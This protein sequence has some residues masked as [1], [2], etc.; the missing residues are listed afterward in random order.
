VPD[1]DGQKWTLANGAVIWL[2][3]T[4]NRQD[5]ITMT[6]FSRG[7]MSIIPAADLPSAAFVSSAK[8]SCGTG[9]M[10]APDLRKFL[11]GKS[12]GVSSSLNELDEIVS[13]TSTNKDFE[14]MLQLAYLSIAPPR[15]DDAVLKSIQQRSIAQLETRKS[16][17]N[18]AL[19][20]TL[21]LLLTNY[22]KRTNLPSEEYYKK[23]DIEKVYALAADRYQDAGDFNFIFLGNID[24]SKMKP[25][26]EKYIGSIPDNPREEK[27]VNNNMVPAKGHVERRL[28]VPMKD[29]K[30]IAYVYFYGEMP[31]TPENVEYVNAIRY[32]LSMRY[33][34]SIREKEGGTYGVSVSASLTS[35]P[36]NNYKIAMNF[37]CAPDRVDYLKG[38]MLDELTKLKQNGVTAEEV[39]K[40]K[41]N[42]LKSDAERLKTN[43]YLIDRVMNYI[44]NG[45]YTPL[46]QHSTDIYNNLNGKKIQEMA[47][48]VFGNDYVDVVMVPEK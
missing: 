2:K 41:L 21:A 4:D 48:K 38:L 1:I 6:A 44:N 7:G 18:S 11:A 40:T 32:I 10:S 35:R 45:V 19:S 14:T 16:D 5:E 36:V 3:K 27:W 26:I 13:G 43:S 23:M 37:S 24:A 15:K 20:D 42:F 47:N 22:S 46:P 39:E 12:V 8:N 33:V 29:P 34:E 31:C 9:S 25:L 30:A 28:T 17:P